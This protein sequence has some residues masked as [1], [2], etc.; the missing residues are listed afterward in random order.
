MVLPLHAFFLMQLFTWF[1][2]FIIRKKLNTVSVFN[3][4]C[5]KRLLR[6]SEWLQSMWMTLKFQR[7][8]ET[9]NWKMRRSIKK[10]RPRRHSQKWLIL[11]RYEILNIDVRSASEN[12]QHCFSLD[13]AFIHKKSFY[14]KKSQLVFHLL[15]TVVYCVS[16]EASPDCCIN[17]DFD[18]YTSLTVSFQDILGRLGAECQTVPGLTAARHDG[19]MVVMSGAVKHGSPLHLAPVKLPLQGYRYSSFLHAGCPS[20]CPTGS[21]TA[22]K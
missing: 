14:S 18:V 20:C 6:S 17:D 7:L 19:V 5:R 22:L 11:C 12:I 13:V 9:L 1:F 2:C 10:F 8:R 15:H 16:S 21:V 3:T 4:H